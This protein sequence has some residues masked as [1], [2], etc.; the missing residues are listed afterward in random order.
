MSSRLTCFPPHPPVA[1]QLS[2]SR[3]RLGA[4]APEPD[5][6]RC[7]RAIHRFKG[8][9]HK[10]FATRE[11]AVSF[12]QSHG[13]ATNAGGTGAQLPSTSAAAPS[14]KAKAGTKRRRVDISQQ[15]AAAEEAEDAAASAQQQQADHCPAE[16]LGLASTLPPAIDD[17]RTYRLV[18]H[19]GAVAH[20]VARF[21]S[22]ALIVARHR[23]IGIFTRSTL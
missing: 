11:E 20:V 22:P 1:P 19:R 15:A 18:W 21:A 14:A 17:S 23:C 8:C 6:H 3:R 12:L 13:V 7:V 5:T 9:I 4:L 16:P 2:P 10:S